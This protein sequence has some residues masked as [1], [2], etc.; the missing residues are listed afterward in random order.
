MSESGEVVAEQP[1]AE[2]Y[3]VA[4]HPRTAS[5]SAVVA[6]HE[7]DAGIDEIAARRLRPGEPS[8]AFLA[9]VRLQER[10]R[11]D[12]DS[13]PPGRYSWLETHEL[14]SVVPSRPVPLGVFDRPRDRR[15]GVREPGR[16]G[17]L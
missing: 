14:H 10:R 9:E 15:F 13:E 3:D 2:G 4:S 16:Y 8:A 17:A 7:R 11:L 5:F 1:Y 6:V 12:P